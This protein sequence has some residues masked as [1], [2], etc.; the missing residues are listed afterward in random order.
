[1]KL[2][3]AKIKKILVITLSNIGDVILTTPVIKVLRR[4]FPQAHLAVL[5]GPRAFSVFKS[6]S[7]IDSK[8]IYDKSICRKNK[9]ALM[10]RLRLDNYDLVVDLRQTAMGIF[11]GA[12]YH[13]SVFAKAPRD[14]THM[15]DRHLWK[16]KSLGLDIDNNKGPYVM[17]SETD[18]DRV[19][20]LFKQ[21]Q[22]KDG[23]KVVAIAP[24]ARNMTK[25]WKKEGYRQ[26][27][28]SLSKEYNVKIII[29]G[30]EQDELLI[31]EIISSIAP[32][33][34]N[35]TG[36]TTI[37][38][39]AFLLTKCSLL[40]SNDSAPMHLGWAMNIP[41]VAIFGP[42]SH[43]KYAPEGPDDIVIRKSLACSPCEQSL[44]PR[45]IR[46]CMKL[47]NADEVFTACKKILDAR[48]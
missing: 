11:L 19:N 20:R 39:L 3:K 32:K 27:I 10:N 30:D 16:L 25:C 47:I 12:R 41:V 31:G 8:I 1:M 38:E 14:L 43:K 35:A 23:Q 9:L 22:I 24:G 18:R 7:R 48:K 40:I 46:E 33:P 4:D 28:V 42:T 15:K 26:L 44:C 13:T 34:F 21:W 45:G 36:K 37:G 17:F 2:D 5:V 29:V 6:D